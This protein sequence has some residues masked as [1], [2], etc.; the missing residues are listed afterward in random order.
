MNKIRLTAI[1]LSC[2]EAEYTYKVVRYIQGYEG[3]NSPPRKVE[4]INEI[5]PGKGQG[6]FQIANSGSYSFI[7]DADSLASN[8]G[9]HL[10]F[11]MQPRLVALYHSQ[12]LVSTLDTT[13]NTGFAL[14]LSTQG[15]L[16]VHIG[17]GDNIEIFSSDW[18]PRLKRWT[19]AS[20]DIYGLEVRLIVQPIAQGVEP[21]GE[22]TRLRHTFKKPVQFSETT[23]LTLAASCHI[24]SRKA[25]NH[26]NGRLDA[27]QISARGSRDRMLAKYDFSRDMASDYVVDISGNNRRGQ[28]INAPSRAMKGHD[29]DGVETDWTKAKYGYGAIHFHQDDFDDARWATDFS[30]EVPK[31]AHSGVYAVDVQGVG[32]DVRDSFVVYVRPSTA[33]T[34]KVRQ[35]YSQ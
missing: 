19:H 32:S 10:E 3:P 23:H 33:T 16:E 34:A 15:R 20:L 24:V 30:I 28:L 17:T 6:W 18:I 9:S 13:E 27:L 8:N 11:Y 26:F 4:P 14:V 35:F 5:P 31:D 2:T 12:T 29:W 25:F 1:K 21:A 22:M 7:P